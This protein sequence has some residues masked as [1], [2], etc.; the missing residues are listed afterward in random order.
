MGV[1]WEVKNADIFKLQF[2]LISL[3]PAGQNWEL[4]PAVIL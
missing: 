2:P 3:A 1:A 4:V